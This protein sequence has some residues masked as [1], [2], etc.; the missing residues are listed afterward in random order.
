LILTKVN[1]L[2]G[3]SIKTKLRIKEKVEQAHFIIL[4][5]QLFLLC[6]TSSKDLTNCLIFRVE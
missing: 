2:E 6:K 3:S 1:P 5:N 4:Q